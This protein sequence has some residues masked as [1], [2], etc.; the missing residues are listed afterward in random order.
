MLTGMAKFTPTEPAMGP[1]AAEVTP[2]TSPVLTPTGG[3]S[4]F[5]VDAQGP[6]SQ[7]RYTRTQ[8][9]RAIGGRRSWRFVAQRV[10]HHAEMCRMVGYALRRAGQRPTQQGAAAGPP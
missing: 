10:G 6:Y 3:A 4:G 2:A 9:E 5:F 7:R 8:T 1:M